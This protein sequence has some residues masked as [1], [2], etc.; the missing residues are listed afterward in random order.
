LSL[1]QAQNS[2]APENLKLKTQVSQ[3]RISAWGVP[4][5][6]RMSAKK[7]KQPAE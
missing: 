5:I 4:N 7:I 1:S 3:Q 6:L 2:G